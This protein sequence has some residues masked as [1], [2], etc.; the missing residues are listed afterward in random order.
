MNMF[1]AKPQAGYKK[2]REFLSHFKVGNIGSFL[3]DS[4]FSL[5]L[6]HKITLDLLKYSG[7]SDWPLKLFEL[8]ILSGSH[9]LSCI[10]V[11]GGINCRYPDPTYRE[12]DFVSR[13]GSW[14]LNF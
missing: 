1:L 9:T 8:G 2:G 5:L 10:E 6:I 13:D 7:S 14:H 4:G 11:M 12:N 3:V